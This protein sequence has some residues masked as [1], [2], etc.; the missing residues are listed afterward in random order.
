VYDNL[1]I[2]VFGHSSCSYLTNIEVFHWIK[3]TKLLFGGILNWAFVMVYS[4]NY[5]KYFKPQGL[6]LIP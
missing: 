2:N 1:R 6:Q 3:A 4:L 5:D